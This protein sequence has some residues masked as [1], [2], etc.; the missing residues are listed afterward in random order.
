MQADE[1][2]SIIK[3]CFPYVAK[4]LLGDDSP[5]AQKA[6]KDLL[7]GAGSAVD[8]ER[9]ADL[10]DGFSTYTTT[11]KNLNN[12]NNNVEEDVSSTKSKLDETEASITLAKDSAEVLLAPEGNL[13]QN[14][15][16]EESASAV[17]AQM[18]DTL[19]DG[20]VDGPK[21][22]RRSLP[23]AL[24]EFLPPL[25]FEEMVSPFVEK[26]EGERK[27]QELTE[28]LSTLVLASSQVSRREDN[29]D[30]NDLAELQQRL[31]NL[32]QDLEPEQVALVSK[33][34]RE[35]FP[36]YAPLVGQLGSKFLSTLLQTASKDIDERL[37][38][39][40]A[41]P[42]S[43]EGSE[44]TPIMISAA[45]GVSNVAKQGASAFSTAASADGSK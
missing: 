15:L 22:F 37:E 36:K 29:G 14:L 42:T 12:N 19:R 6:L 31:S 45:R 38:E 23:L 11:T 2:Y 5:R 40:L 13:M 43:K 8:A 26:T 3:S 4:R 33:E 44:R 30:N 34:I 17:V 18:K 32:F 28:K 9:I 16:V 25:P 7:Y 35:S 10:A 1:N 27:A 24:G 41:S 21:R 39:I 20:L